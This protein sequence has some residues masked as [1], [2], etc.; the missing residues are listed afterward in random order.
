MKKQRALIILGIIFSSLAYG[1][2]SSEQIDLAGT[3]IGE[4]TISESPEPD[5]VTFIIEQENGEYSGTLTSELGLYENAECE[6]IELNNSTLTFQFSFFS[7]NS[8]VTI[9]VTVE[10]EGDSMTGTWESG[11]G[12][13]G[14]INLKRENG[15]E[16]S[17]LVLDR[18]PFDEILLRY[19]RQ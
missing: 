9:Y 4:V 2:A 10:V 1:F 12:D 5:I 17:R 7:G 15:M 11:G 19:L 14:T 16:S 13:T 6:D 18:V 8:D 3:W